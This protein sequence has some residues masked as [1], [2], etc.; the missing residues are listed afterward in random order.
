[1]SNRADENRMARLMGAHLMALS[2]AMAVY[3][4]ELAKHFLGFEG[5]EDSEAAGPFYKAMRDLEKVGF[6]S[7]MFDQSEEGGQR[8]MRSLAGANATLVENW[9]ELM[10]Q[11]WKAFFD[12]LQVRKNEK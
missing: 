10:G 6:A 12:A 11:P 8:R 7:S 9:L 5:E 1:M 3:Q 2:K 4:S